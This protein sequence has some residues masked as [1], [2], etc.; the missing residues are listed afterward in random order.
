MTLSQSTF[1]LLIQETDHTGFIRSHPIC[2]I[3]FS[4]PDCAV[5]EV[6]K[7]KLFELLQQRFPKLVLGE[8]NCANSPQLAAQMSVFTIPTLI[9]YFEGKEG[10]RKSRSF[11]LAELAQQLARP[12]EILTS[13]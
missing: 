9:V 5:C 1:H 6:L 2:A 10:L 3:Y 12:Y 4:G 8:V 11:S 7:P 13:A